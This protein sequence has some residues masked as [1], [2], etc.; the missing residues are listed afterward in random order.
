MSLYDKQ[1]RQRILS[2]EELL[3]DAF[4]SM[5]RSVSNGRDYHVFENDI[6]STREA[7]SDILVSFRIK[8]GTVPEGLTSVNEIL[9]YVLKPLGIMRR[10]VRLE[11][12]WYKDACGAYMAVLKKDGRSVA[13]I[14]DRFMG[15][16]Y[17]DHA[18]GKKVRI[19]RHT[20]AE[21]EEDAICLYKPLPLRAL[22]VTDL[23]KFAF[24]TL[25]GSDYRGMI[26]MSL[27]AVLVGMLIPVLNN[28]IYK[29]I[30]SSESLSLLISTFTAML[31]I[32][33]CRLFLDVGKRMFVIRAGRKIRLSMEAASMM[34]ILSL[35]PNFFSGHSSGELADRIAYMSTICVDIVNIIMSTGITAFLSLIYVIQMATF[36][37]YMVVPG[38][39]LIV[40]MLGIT[41]IITFARMKYN[42]AL[43]EKSA[44]ENA[45]SYSLIS[46][47][48]KIKL[49]G[50]EKRAFAKWGFAYAEKADYL[51]N[52]PLIL[53]ISNVLVN[54][55]PIIG[56][57]VIYFAATSSSVAMSEYFAF[58]AAYAM[59]MGAFTS[60]M[61][62]ATGNTSVIDLI[63]PMI[64]MIKPIL[65]AEPEVAEGKV[66]A[67]SLSGKIELYDVSF[68]Y[69]KA[70]HNVI[71]GMSL[72]I[73]KGEYVGIVGKTGCGKSTLVRLLL[74]FETPDSGS[75]FYDDNDLRK[76]DIRSVRRN[77]GTVMQDG[78]LFLGDVFSNIIISA[79][80]L[81]EE[82]AWEA[83][84]IAGIADDIKAMP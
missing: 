77:I 25:N 60:L 75:I 53:K 73:K 54:A 43:M 5:A 83:A 81:D 39:M 1:I 17:I 22:E 46:G 37:P 41:V 65:Q 68:A 84:E 23:I 15:Y 79:P 76:L 59:V 3:G 40:L 51:Y 6:E 44:K 70:D 21:L 71:D 14:P 69:E 34:R 50:A 55:I 78:K 8:A 80:H 27:A 10:N 52:A 56:T 28:A 11:E 47:I 12:G 72:K 7:I 2:D 13:L 9:D 24:G 19:N 82:A 64:N 20:A 31:L 30:L 26:L 48:K 4:A 35:K 58:N 61:A 29:Y 42:R 16:Y 18:F 62:M 57:V 63:G 67:S 36:G 66:V 32:S 33:I 38:V 74:G 45:W 49:S